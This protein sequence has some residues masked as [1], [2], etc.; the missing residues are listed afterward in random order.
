VKKFGSGIDA[1]AVTTVLNLS[2]RDFL[3][4]S[5]VLAGGTFVLGVFTGCRTEDLPA[6]VE[7]ARATG[8]IGEAAFNPNVFIA[9]NE[10]GDVFIVN[11]RSEM[12]QG[13]RS[14]VPPLIADEMEADLDRVHVVQADGD[15]MFGN[16]NTDGSTSMRNLF[17]QWR[18]AGATARLMLVSA[19]AEKWGVPVEECEAEFH[20]IYHR[21]SG[22]QAGYGELAEAA[23]S[24]PVPTDPAFKPREKWR[25]TGKE[26]RGVDNRDI[27]TGRATYGLDVTLPGLLYASVEHCPTIGGSLV[28]YDD[29]AALAVPGVREVIE[30]PVPSMPTGYAP[31]GGLAVVADNTWAAFKGREAL[32]AEWDLGANAAYDS[33]SYRE[34][35]EKSASN[36]GREIRKIG[37]VEKGFADA[38]STLEAMYYV[39]MLAHAPMEVP[40][41]TAWVKEDGTCECWAP[42]QAPQAA[43]RTVA[44]FL[45][46]DQSDVTVHVTLLGGAFGRKSKADFVAEAAVISKAVR[47]PVK[48]TWMREDCIRFDYFHS[49]SAQYMKAGFDENGRATS[50]LH[51]TSFPSIQSTFAAGVTH[52]D[53]SELNLGFLTVPYDIENML[54][55]NGPATAHVRIGWLRSVSNIHHA[56]ALN[57]FAGEMAHAVGR[58]QVDY[59]LELLG[60]DRSLNHLFPRRGPYGE[61]LEKA[62]YHTARLKGVLRRAADEAGWGQV[63]PGP[64][65][66]MG[67]AVHYS[68]G[69]Y[70]AWILRIAIEDEKVR[71]IRADGAIDCGTY[72]NLDRVRAQM[73][74]NLVFGLTLAFN[75]NIT[76]KNGSIEQSNFHDYRL[77]RMDEV[78]ETH[79]HIVENEM[80]PGGVGE[81]GL[82]PVAPALTNAILMA[83]GSPIRE[84]PIRT[85]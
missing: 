47:A 2:R 18:K 70:A 31:L 35:L 43:R 44:S 1:P 64:G 41:A 25:Y 65:E 73:E 57:A 78:P 76:A 62:P 58:D 8:S 74:G 66:G 55:E 52:A 63:S 51:R 11:P 61:N 10:N 38:K 17:D 82:P 80:I 28:S 53:G 6:V 72:V 12:G 71:V 83:T 79:V 60:T 84:L 30:I 5:A 34:A 4:S 15:A 77:L 85:S 16:Q 21:A 48:L 32:V 37:D 7:H 81:P 13:V 39:P 50:W 36:P 40:T 75:G 20:V 24:Q 23:T 42:T 9:L 59:L 69:S 33:T 54:L 49:P 3:K 22:R 56:F 27:V 26:I 68:F 45:E 29:S 67:A 14:S 46:I 19:A